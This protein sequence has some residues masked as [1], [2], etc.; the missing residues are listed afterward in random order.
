MYIYIWY[1]N[2]DKNTLCIYNW[3][4]EN[5]FPLSNLPN[6]THNSPAHFAS[7]GFPPRSNGKVQEIS[8][9][10]GVKTEVTN[11]NNPGFR[12]IPQNCHSF[13][14]FDSPKTGNEK[15]PLIFNSWFFF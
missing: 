4:E 11:P 7:N 3:S 15:K 9:S 1:N 5:N 12:E 10:S 2:N 6:K 13:V 14:L 8:T